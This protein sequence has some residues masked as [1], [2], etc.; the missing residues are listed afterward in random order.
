MRLRLSKLPALTSMGNTTLGEAGKTVTLGG[1][2][3]GGKIQLATT[4]AAPLPTCNGAAEGTWYGVTDA[5]APAWNT[6]VSGGGSVHMPVY[7]NGT[8][9]IAH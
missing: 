5:S 9:W 7:C 1:T 8:N 2:L 4:T 3:S 6:A